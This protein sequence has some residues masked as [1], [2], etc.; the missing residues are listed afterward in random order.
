MLSDVTPLILT[1]NEEANIGRT[2]APLDWANRI[3]VIDSFS[4][5]DTVTIAR[6]MPQV[7]VL[8]RKFDNFTS[9]WNFGLAQIRTPWV[10]TL[11]ADYVCSPKLAAE[12]DHC[13]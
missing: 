10:L 3:V 5:D 2:L 12:M 1:R 11:D 13:T 7:D 6:Q 9:Q 4:S 8:Q